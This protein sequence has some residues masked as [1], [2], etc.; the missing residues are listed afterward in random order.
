MHRRSLFAPDKIARARRTE[1]DRLLPLGFEED[2]THLKACFVC[3]A[4]R[5]NRFDAKAARVFVHDDRNADADV[6]VF[7]R[8]LVA[9]VLRRA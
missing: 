8:L 1:V 7:H 2:I 3:G 5:R 9:L 4:V 6:G